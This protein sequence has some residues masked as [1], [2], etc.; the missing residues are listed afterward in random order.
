MEDVLF[1]SFS[2]SP[3]PV[4]A[5][6]RG[7]SIQFEQ[8]QQQQGGLD[9]MAWQSCCSEEG[10]P[11]PC[12]GFLGGR[13]CVQERGKSDHL[14][15]NPTPPQRKSDF[16]F[17]S[18]TSSIGSY[19]LNRHVGHHGWGGGW[20]NKKSFLLLCRPPSPRPTTTRQEGDQKHGR[21]MCPKRERSMSIP[22]F[23]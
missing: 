1:F 14:N 2:F 18:P 17:P 22:N 3:F 21:K 7:I 16:F 11:S 15:G 13:V 19:P 6:W 12:S 20:D 8:Q 10:L 5:L 9:G 4:N 23:D